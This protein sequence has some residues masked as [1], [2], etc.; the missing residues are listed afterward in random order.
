MKNKKSVRII[1]CAMHDLMVD[2]ESDQI[3][4]SYVKSVWFL[5]PLG[6]YGRNNRL[7]AIRLE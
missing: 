7:S 1:Y 5:G 6:R 3:D 2:P 4:N